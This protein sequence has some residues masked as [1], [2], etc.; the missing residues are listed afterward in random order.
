[1]KRHVEFLTPT[2]PASDVIAS[3][4]AAIVDRGIYTNG[5][6]VEARFVDALEAWIGSVHVSVTSSGMTALELA[7][8]ALLPAGRR[9][10]LV[11]SFTFAAGP[12]A[13]CRHG[14]EPLFFDV[15]AATWQPC[16]AEAEALL[17]TRTDV[18][19]VLLT[20]TFGV[21]NAEIA[22]W[23]ALAE[24]HNLPLI[25]DSAAGFG[26]TYPWDEP[27]GRRGSCEIFSLHAT[28]TLAVGEGGAIAVRDPELRSTLECLKNFG[29]DDARQATLMGTNAKLGEFASSI[30]IRQLDVLRHRVKL[31]QGVLAAYRMRLEP[32]GF[33][34]QPGAD[35]AALAFVS[36]LLP[37]PSHREALTDALRSDG[38][39]C[40]TYYNPPVHEQP[41]FA[42]FAA[43]TSLSATAD[44]SARIVSLPM[45]DHL[46]EEAID[47][48]AN[49]AESLLHG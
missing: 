27:L 18:G 48:I 11:P 37:T 2:F 13:L 44:M 14:L 4:Y 16:I 42:S 26:S 38:V 24:H 19:G 28:K 12:L 15:D 7:I 25:I 41:A 10:V 21:A 34:F 6:P 29:F 9:K 35:H 8:Q 31:R 30:G 33:T 40:R 5:G 32:L 17:G 45:A 46:P 20:S 49:I 47:R 3:D 43:G 1:M 39:Q 23:E 22:R 36:A